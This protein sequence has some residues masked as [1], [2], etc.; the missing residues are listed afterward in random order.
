MLEKY[1]FKLLHEVVV[2]ICADGF[3][4]E[5]RE[6]WLYRLGTD[7]FRPA[8]FCCIRKHH[9]DIMWKSNTVTLQSVAQVS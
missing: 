6:V 4:D 7:F 3:S 1:F 2:E 5:C 8:M 9:N